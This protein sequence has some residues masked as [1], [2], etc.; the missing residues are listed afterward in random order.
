MRN[1]TL[2]LAGLVLVT[3]SWA[4]TSA[5]LGAAD[6][7]QQLRTTGITPP[8]TQIQ[9]G[10]DQPRQPLIDSSGM[11]SG[12]SSAS[13][14]SSR[15]EGDRAVNAGQVRDTSNR[16]DDRRLLRGTARLG[17]HDASDSRMQKINE[18]VT[19]IKRRRA[20]RI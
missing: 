9:S 10:P 2:L 4:Q 8:G 14:D 7:S 5:Q 20:Q 17:A 15:V 12:S 19:E 1:L 18:L 16:R 11:A 13:T 6:P 3:A